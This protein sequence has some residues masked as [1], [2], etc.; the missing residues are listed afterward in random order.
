MW[1]SDPSK[2]RFQNGESFDELIKRGEEVLGKYVN[3]EN[4]LL[5]SHEDITRG[6]LTAATKRIEDFWEY[7]IPNASITVLD[8]NDENRLQVLEIGETKHLL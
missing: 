3:M 2:V 6:I 7:E 8:K 5:V 1:K 4:I